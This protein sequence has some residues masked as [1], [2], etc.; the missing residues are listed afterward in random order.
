MLFFFTLSFSDCLLCSAPQ[1]ATSTAPQAWTGPISTVALLEAKQK[2]QDEQDILLEAYLRAQNLVR[3]PTPKDGACLV[4]I[5]DL[6]HI[7]F[8]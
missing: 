8:S 3:K 5:I 1:Q 2:G 7:I 4:F 6:L